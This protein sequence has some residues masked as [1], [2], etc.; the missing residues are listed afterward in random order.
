M[1]NTS[2]KREKY[3]TRSIILCNRKVVDIAKTVLDSAPVDEGRPLELVIRELVKVRT[4]D[5]NARMW[6]GPLK[7]IAEQVYVDGRTYSAELWHEYLKRE[8]MP[9]DDD[10]DIDTL[11]KNADT[12]H[13]WDFLPKT[14]GSV[15]Y[16]VGSTTEL[17]TKGFALY[18]EQIYAFGASLGVQFH[19]S[20]AEVAQN[21]VA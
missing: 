4:P 5:Q 7:D 18:L 13:K 11:V 6:A 1:N 9:E 19:M 21:A 12:Y 16:C 3:P 20:P 10:H 2:T 17:T 8:F 14:G 15:R